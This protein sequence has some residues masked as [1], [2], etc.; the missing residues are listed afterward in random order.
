MKYFKITANTCCTRIR[1]RVFDKTYTKKFLKVI[2]VLYRNCRNTSSV[3][4]S[5]K[6]LAASCISRTVELFYASS[7]KGTDEKRKVEKEKANGASKINEKS[8]PKII[9]NS[10]F[11]NVF[12]K[13][14]YNGSGICAKKSQG[15]RLACRFFNVYS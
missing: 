14:L 11:Q 13:T 15:K 7:K 2:S 8:K 6:L 10:T 12:R 5:L 1:F 9:K 4:S 3:Q